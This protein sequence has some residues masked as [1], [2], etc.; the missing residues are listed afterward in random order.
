MWSYETTICG[1]S[2]IFFQNLGKTTCTVFDG[3]T[4][5]IYFLTVNAQVRTNG[6]AGL[7]EANRAL[8]SKP[9][10]SSVII[11]PSHIQRFNRKSVFY[12]QRAFAFTPFCFFLF[13]IGLHH[14][15]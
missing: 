14:L 10:N 8:G 15:K 5:L 11:L 7:Q 1:I 2:K 4:G 3:M 12:I 6:T 9:G 13:V